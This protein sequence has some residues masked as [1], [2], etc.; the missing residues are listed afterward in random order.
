MK[1]IEIFFILKETMKDNQFN[2]KHIVTS[3]K[4]FEIRIKSEGMNRQV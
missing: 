2:D 4:I 3:N 1:T